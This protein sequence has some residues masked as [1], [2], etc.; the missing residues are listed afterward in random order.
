MKEYR[1]NMCLYPYAEND[2]RVGGSSEAAVA[3][4]VGPLIFLM[5]DTTMTKQYN[6]RL[7]RIKRRTF[8]NRSSAIVSSVGSPRPRH[9]I[10]EI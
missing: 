3:R 1:K 6:D 8:E 2:F 4:T 7:A 9:V 10:D 5:K